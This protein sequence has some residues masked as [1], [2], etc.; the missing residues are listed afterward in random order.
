MPIEVEFANKIIKSTNYRFGTAIDEK[1]PKNY[2]LAL[3]K[4]FAFLTKV[5]IQI[6]P[7]RDFFRP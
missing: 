3:T 5:F 2:R 6:L 4:S 1:D 7:F